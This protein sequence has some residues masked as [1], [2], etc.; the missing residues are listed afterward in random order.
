MNTN[1]RAPMVTT[2]IHRPNAPYLRYLK[3]MRPIDSIISE[4]E[5][6]ITYDSLLQEY[7]ITTSWQGIKQYEGWTNRTFQ[8]ALEMADIA[9]EAMSEHR[10]RMLQ[11]VEEVLA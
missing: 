5:Q 6:F 8:D 4:M 11:Q 2:T 10:Q 3:W 9:W 1:D 7:R